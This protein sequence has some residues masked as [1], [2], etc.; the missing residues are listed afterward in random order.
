MMRLTLLATVLLVVAGSLF[1]Q[2]PQTMS[3][4]RSMPPPAGMTPYGNILYPGGAPATHPM[5]LGATVAGVPYPGVAPAVGRGGHG[6]RPQTIVVPYA[7]P[8]YAGGYGGYGYAQQQQPNITVVMPQQP[9]PSVIINNHYGS[10]PGR[11]VTTAET[12]VDRGG[13]KVYEPTASAPAAAPAPREPVAKPTGSLVRE[14]KPN[15]YLIA[16]KD[17]TVRQAIG[18]WSKN[19]ALHFVTPAASVQQISLNDLDRDATAKLNADRKLDFDLP[20]E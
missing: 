4:Y 19:G 8:V 13:L 2:N 17:G 11:V 12:S 9:A 16:L 7:M 1:G 18:Y 3:P 15:I 6:G 10:D 20:F 5:A 14:D